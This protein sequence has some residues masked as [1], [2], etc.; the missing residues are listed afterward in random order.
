MAN[1]SG[2]EM[3]YFLI[4]ILKKTKFGGV[5]SYESLKS[6]K[7]DNF[8]FCVVI[9]SASLKET[10]GHWCC[11]FINKEKNGIFFDSYGIKPWGAIY[12]FL[13]EH[14]TSAIY[15]LNLLQNLQTQICGAYVILVLKW[16]DR[17]QTLKQILSHFSSKTQLNDLLVSRWF[18][19]EKA[20]LKRL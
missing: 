9:N 6:L 15:N 19:A 14:S 17:G 11:I 7:I 16:L 3:E 1:L 10:S 5:L 2:L 18:A 12:K 13:K 20:R 4:R 8:P